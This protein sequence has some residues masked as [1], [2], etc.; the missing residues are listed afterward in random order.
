MIIGSLNINSVASK[1]EHLREV[2]GNYLDVLTI[3]ETK[4]DDSFPTAQL[5]IDGY[6]EPYRLDR[7]R[8]GGGVLIYVREDIP[9]KPLNKHNF[10]KNVE[11]LFIEINL[12]KTKILFF[13]GYR[14]DHKTYGLHEVD[15][16]EQIGLAL[17]VYRV[18]QKKNPPVFQNLGNPL[19]FNNFLFLPQ[20]FS[21]SSRKWILSVSDTQDTFK[22]N[23]QRYT[24]WP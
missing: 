1:L 10:T 14:S 16:F 15:Y 8:H 7:N 23:S 17:D 4:L 18:A 13:G 2:I 22:Y 5:L 9:S 20:R 6:S 11:G 19:F 3:Q 21:F 12:R 24:L